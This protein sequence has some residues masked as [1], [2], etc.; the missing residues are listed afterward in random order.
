MNTDWD[1]KSEEGHIG[2]T[3]VYKR[4]K[5]IYEEKA[6]IKLY[7]DSGAVAVIQI[8][9]IAVDNMELEDDF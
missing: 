7:N 6:D 2:L 5:L 8:P 3:N 4:L 9:Y 1:Q